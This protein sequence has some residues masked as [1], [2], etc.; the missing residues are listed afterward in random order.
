PEHVMGDVMSELQT[1]R[2]VIMGMDSRGGYQIIKARTPL[3]EL[4]KFNAALRSI[5]QGRAKV[6]SIFAE[7]APVPNEIQKK[8]TEDYR[9]VEVDNHH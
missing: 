3:A 1:R 8:L 2:S 6:K 7:Y 5:T 4:D 9:K